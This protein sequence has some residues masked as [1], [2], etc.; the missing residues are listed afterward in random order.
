MTD[1][2]AARPLRGQLPGLEGLAVLAVTL[3]LALWDSAMWL[4]VPFGLIV[5]T[6][7]S[8]DDYGLRWRLGSLRFHLIVAAIVLGGYLAGHYLFGRLVQQAQFHLRFPANLHL[9]IL[10][11][12]INVALPE[13]FFFRGYLQ[14]SFDK[15]WGRPY[16]LLG[17]RWGWGLPAAALLFA[18]CHLIYGDITQLKVFFFG[19]FA[20]WLRERSDSIAAPILYHAAGNVLLQIMVVSFR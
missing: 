14:T 7:R 13:E 4:L 9:L 15:A 2:G 1:E 18:L 10:G 5:V 11:Q 8:F 19:L 12:L 6:K 20:G 3:P 17:A 16:Q